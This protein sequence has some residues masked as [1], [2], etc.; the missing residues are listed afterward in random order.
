IMETLLKVLARTQSGAG[1]HEEAMLAAGTFTVA[2]GEHFQKYLQ[3]FMP[4]VRAGLQDHMQWQVCL[5]TVGV[6]GDVSRAVGQAVFP[7]CDE[8]VSIILTNLGSPSVHRNI[9]PELLTVLGDC[10]LA[11][12]SNFSKYLDAVLTI[13][14][15]AMVM[16]VQMVSSN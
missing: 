3:Q 16:S 14:R 1:V 6:L 5:S 2:A 12:E 11:I 10:A 9:K 4:F 13:L 15:Q 8:L 7:Y